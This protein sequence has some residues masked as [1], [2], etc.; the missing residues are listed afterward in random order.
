V[1]NVLLPALESKVG[2]PR[3]E[4]VEVVLEVLLVAAGEVSPFATAARVRIPAEIN[5]LKFMA[6][7]LW[8]VLDTRSRSVSE[9]ALYREYYR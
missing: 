9:K 4:S 8:K 6:F 2:E 3:S 5:N 7:L 1:L